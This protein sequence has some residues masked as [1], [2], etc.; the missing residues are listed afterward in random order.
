MKNIKFPSNHNNKTF[1]NNFL[2]FEL[3]HFFDLVRDRCFR[4]EGVTSR[5]NRMRDGLSDSASGI[6]VC[7]TTSKATAYTPIVC[8]CYDLFAQ[9]QQVPVSPGSPACDHN[10]P[11]NL[12]LNRCQP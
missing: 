11:A 4:I 7:C 9:Q 6:A 12:C 5:W 8:K 1:L 3:V 10:H 2:H